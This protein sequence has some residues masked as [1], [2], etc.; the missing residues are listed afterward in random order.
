LGANIEQAARENANANTGNRLSINILPGAH[1]NM[2]ANDT[3]N[4][5]A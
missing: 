1:G 5:S 2:G 4:P 3:E